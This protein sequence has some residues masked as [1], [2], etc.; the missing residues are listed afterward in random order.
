MNQKTIEQLQVG[1]SAQRK[2]TINIE[3]VETF[4]KIIGDLNP[5]HFDDEYAKRTIFKKRISHGMLIGS[6]FSPI[7][8]MELPGEGSIYLSQSLRFRRPVYLGDIITAKVT[9]KAID[10]AKERVYFDCIA[11]NQNNETV[12]IGEAELIPPKGSEKNE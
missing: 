8:G 6:L 7:F 1:E 4:G 9:V 12:I 11:T 10:L 2:V 5:V 3:L